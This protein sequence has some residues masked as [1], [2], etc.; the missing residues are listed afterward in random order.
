M[1]YIAYENNHISNLFMSYLTVP[2]YQ[3]GPG[4]WHGAGF[5]DPPTRCGF[6]QSSSSKEWK[7]FLAG[8]ML[9][10]L[11]EIL[12][13]PLWHLIKKKKGTKEHG[14]KV[15]LSVLFLGEGKLDGCHCS[16]AE[17]WMGGVALVKPDIYFFNVLC[18]SV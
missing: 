18:F 13:V 3:S 6:A 11:K 4:G 14:L 10:G 9:P 12:F 16:R 1:W 17:T 7:Y 15:W 8:M 5:V 2:S